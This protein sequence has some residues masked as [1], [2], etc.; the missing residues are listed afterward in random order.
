MDVA[1][2]EQTEE[3][4]IEFEGTFSKEEVDFIM[5]VGI[6]E[7]MHRGAIATKHIPVEPPTDKDGNM[8]KQ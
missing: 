3:G 7:L 4:I 2:K 8:T 1:F 6:M 5:R